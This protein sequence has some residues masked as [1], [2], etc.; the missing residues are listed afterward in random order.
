MALKY[1][2]CYNEGRSG[3]PKLSYDRYN[4]MLNALNATG[5]PFL[6]QLC[7]WGEDGPWNWA[8]TMTNTWRMSGDITA[9][10][11]REDDRCGTCAVN[12][13][14]QHY[15]YKC[16]VMNIIEKAASIVHKGYKGSWPD[17]DSLE[18]SREASRTR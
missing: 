18:V 3:T 16:S 4:T 15:G 17:L 12:A 11:D 5:R 1:D 10:F 6:Y 8:T 13:P 2:N 9:S 14:C 7:H